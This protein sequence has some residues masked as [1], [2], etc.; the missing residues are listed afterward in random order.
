MLN[1]LPLE[2][3]QIYRVIKKLDYHLKK[4]LKNIKDDF[5]NLYGIDLITDKDNK[6]W[7]LELNGNPNWQIKQDSQNLKEIKT[8]IFDEILKILSN[9]F[10][11]KNYHI[12]NWEKLN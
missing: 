10:Y 6:T 9:H 5:V 12:E 7:I 1:L 8:N 4:F 11:N 2:R 3:E